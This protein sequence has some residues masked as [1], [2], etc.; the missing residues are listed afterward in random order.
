M[1]Y[2]EMIREVLRQA[3]EPLSS[4]QIW[5]KACELGL[6]KKLS[7][8]GNTPPANVGA[9]IYRQIYKDIRDRGKESQFIFASRK[10]TTFW[11]RDRAGELENLNLNDVSISIKTKQKNQFYERDLHPLL[12]TFLY[13][14]PNFSLQ[15]KTIYHEKS[16]KDTNGKDKWSYPDIVGVYFPYEDYQEETLNFLHNIEQSH[17]KLFS[18]ELK[19]SLDFSNLKE[20]Y[21]QAVSNSSWA[22][23]GYLVVFKEIDDEVLGELRRLNQSFGIGVI[24]LESDIQS[25]RILLS[26]RQKELDISTLDILLDKNPDFKNFICDINKQIKAGVGI[27]IKANFDDILDEECVQ[28]YLKEKHIEE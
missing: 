25:S 24:K 10:P 23:E 20:S 11:L 2:K 14:N 12:V 3:K 16:K 17:F 1:T 28:K 7:S 18:F 15:C 21:F 19:I 13:N 27:E 5:S 26:S 6:D 22:N 4:E 8:I 9:Q